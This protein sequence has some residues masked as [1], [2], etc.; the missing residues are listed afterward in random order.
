M[1]RH[2]QPT[3]NDVFDDNAQPDAREAPDGA[4][5]KPT[6]VTDKVRAKEAVAPSDYTDVIFGGSFVGA[7]V[8]GVANA[9]N[10]IRH[11]FYESFVKPPQDLLNLDNVS[12][13]AAREKHSFADLF[14][15]R[16]REYQD[17]TRKEAHGEISGLE[18]AKKKIEATLKME[19]KVH[20]RCVE[21]YG[22]HTKGWRGWTTDVWK[23]RNHVGTFA[24]RSAA[25]TMATTTV[26]S[27]GAI[28]TL[29]YTKHLLDRID[30]NEIQAK[31][32]LVKAAVSGDRVAPIGKS[33]VEK[34]TESSQADVQEKGR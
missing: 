3:P 30:E 19:K 13:A 18:Q 20:E 8:F 9:I 27:L 5:A 22:I 33:Y 4:S 25:L 2:K 24:R 23:Q 17:I 6:T 16:K 21:K 10:N 1:A 28:A 26:V 15:E 34:L 31:E 32:A 7:A 12:D 14:R 29:K 11:N